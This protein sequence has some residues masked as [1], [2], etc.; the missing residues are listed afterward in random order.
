MSVISKIM[1]TFC[2]DSTPSPQTPST[3]LSDDVYR[4]KYRE[5]EDDICVLFNKMLIVEFDD[6]VLEEIKS[7]RGPFNKGGLFKL[8]IWG[9]ETAPID[10]AFLEEA[11]RALNKMRR[12]PCTD[13]R[14][15]KRDF[16]YVSDS[17]NILSFALPEKPNYTHIIQLDKDGRGILSDIQRSGE[18]VRLKI[19]GSTDQTISINGTNINVSGG[20][21]D[22]RYDDKADDPIKFQDSISVTCVG[23][24]KVEL[25]YVPGFGTRIGLDPY[26]VSRNSVVASHIA[27]G[28]GTNR[29]R[30]NQQTKDAMI[31]RIVDK[32]YELTEL[33]C[34]QK[35]TNLSAFITKNYGSDSLIYTI[36][37]NNNTILVQNTAYMSNLSEIMIT[38]C[39]KMGLRSS[40]NIVA[41]SDPVKSFELLL[42]QSNSGSSSSPVTPI[43]P[44]N[45]R[46]QVVTPVPSSGIDW[47]SQGEAA[48]EKVERMIEQYSEYKDGTYMTTLENDW[49]DVV[50]EY[51]AFDDSYR[52][53]ASYTDPEKPFS[54]MPKDAEKFFKIHFCVGSLKG[55][56]ESEENMF[57]APSPGC[58]SL[59]ERMLVP[60]TRHLPDRDNVVAQVIQSFDTYTKLE[61]T[62]IAHLI[63][64]KRFKRYMFLE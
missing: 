8:V 42:P 13:P 43:L 28:T 9:I 1:N 35:N 40:G 15:L 31:G 59:C 25:S 53:T 3:A 36:F 33:V 54:E 30:A 61:Y 23:A 37:K 5:L 51:L 11:F 12:M 52:R 41:S 22:F 50:D 56:L 29:Q 47:Q 58:L 55:V 64:I 20:T 62:S 19:T 18:I 16:Y 7:I 48:A 26:M 60:Y 4:A 6:A 38:I 14:I 27:N 63:L 34:A 21:Y 2:A 24:S 49:G 32:L 46:P 45:S 39:D 17:T 10:V 44:R 57:V